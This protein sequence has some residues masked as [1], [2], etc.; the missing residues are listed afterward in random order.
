MS[1]GSLYVISAPSGA[2][3]TSLV[4]A[5]VDGL[6]QLRVSV[7]YT[8]RARRTGETDGVNYHFIARETFLDKIAHGDFLEYAEVFGN[9]YGTSQSWV[10]Q[11]LQSGDD[12]ILEID[13]QGAQQIRQ[14]VSGV[15]TI[16][17][18]P[19]DREILMQRL[20]NRGQDSEDI[21]ARRM[22]EAVSEMRH[23]AESDYLVVND[24]FEH[25][26]DDL[27]AIVRTTRLR[28]PLQSA[29]HEQLIQKLL[30]D[31]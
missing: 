11:Q 22:A 24:S 5:L 25:A 7:S 3:K 13:W 12:I 17:I 26:L 14:L 8:T 4:E 27:K 10:E 30:S 23:Y 2:G 28:L 29:R 15:I 6:P 20:R 1:K 21:I 16:F 31:I 19:P 9:L 18:L